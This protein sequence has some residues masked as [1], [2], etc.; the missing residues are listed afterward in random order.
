MEASA[1]ISKSSGKTLLVLQRS[2]R[3]RNHE[4]K[5]NRGASASCETFRKAFAEWRL[6]QRQLETNHLQS[7]SCKSCATPQCYSSTEKVHPQDYIPE[8]PPRLP[9]IAFCSRMQGCVGEGKV[10]VG[11]TCK[12]KAT[13]CNQNDFEVP[14]REEEV[15]STVCCKTDIS[16]AVTSNNWTLVT[17]LRR[18]KR[19]FFLSPE[20]S[21]GKDD[22]SSDTSL[23]SVS[24]TGGTVV[25]APNRTT[26]EESK[27]VSAIYS[28]NETLLVPVGPS[29]ELHRL[30]S[31][32]SV[33]TLV[34]N[35][36]SVKSTSGDRTFR[37]CDVVSGAGSLSSLDDLSN[38]SRESQL[39]RREEISTSNF[40]GA[41]HSTFNYP[42]HSTMNYQGTNHLDISPVPSS[43]VA[44][45][46]RLPTATSPRSTNTRVSTRQVLSVDSQP[47]KLRC[48]CAFSYQTQDP[49]RQ[50][51]SLNKP[52]QIFPPKRQRS[53]NSPNSEVTRPNNDIAYKLKLR[54]PSEN[55]KEAVKAL[56]PKNCADGIKQK[57]SQ[58]ASLRRQTG[59]VE[60]TTSP[61]IFDSA[62]CRQI[63]RSRFQKLKATG[64]LKDAGATVT[65]AKLPT[66]SE[67]AV[68]SRN[69]DAYKSGDLKGKDVDEV[70]TII[71]P[72]RTSR[73]EDSVMTKTRKK[74]A[75]RR[76]IDSNCLPSLLAFVP[77]K[78]V[79][80]VVGTTVSTPAGDPTGTMTMD[81][82]AAWLCAGTKGTTTDTTVP[83]S[84]GQT[85]PMSFDSLQTS[86]DEDD[87]PRSDNSNSRNSTDGFNTEDVA[88]ISALGN[89]NKRCTLASGSQQRQNNIG[90]KKQQNEMRRRLRRTKPISR[91]HRRESSNNIRRKVYPHEEQSTESDVCIRT[92]G[93]L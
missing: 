45:S 91:R 18:G 60:L 13:D 77:C 84:P 66:S 79:K 3:P 65:Q 9:P 61:S 35:D 5:E 31:K 85:R 72:L 75:R 67:T 22:Q 82:V 14:A 34:E 42:L 27:N 80:R 29:R 93:F 55:A 62:S 17:P 1:Q 90:C 47:R 24:S 20:L 87:I 8:E 4:D 78:S 33:P 92:L 40:N 30:I 41:F 56:R 38:I 64:R 48:H 15:S 7:E 6:N 44:T 76:R 69:N 12:R 52:T 2:T 54:K 46:S 68:E 39:N 25:A 63:R 58:S 37:K 81:N 57:S 21:E 73:P 26:A 36:D 19:R 32:S 28:R 43:S 89:R 10:R 16:V 86:E 70:A 53:E 50:T 11:K 59:Q 23:W 51:L 74:T 49:E 71:D 83:T 88:R